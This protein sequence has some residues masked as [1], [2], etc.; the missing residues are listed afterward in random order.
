VLVTEIL[1]E[2]RRVLPFLLL[3]F[4]TD[5]NTAFLNE[6]VRDYCAAAGVLFKR[7]RPYR[8]NDQAHIEQKNGAV[9]RKRYHVPATPYQRLLED[10][11]VPEEIKAHLR[12]MAS[13]LDPVRLLRD[14]RAAQQRF[15]KMADRTGVSKQAAPTQPTLEEFL[16]GLA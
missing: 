9:V 14:I 6:T 1:N 10:P 12:R 2:V 16:H 4:D 15:V 3:G 8:E 5:N 11:W 7:C 13:G